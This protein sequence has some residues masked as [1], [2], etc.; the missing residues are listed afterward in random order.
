MLFSEV[1]G[2][3]HIKN[4]LITG[5]ENGRIPHAQLLVG[6]GVLPIAIA[7]AQYLLCSNKDGE[8]TGGNES[9]NLKF[10]KLS[11]PDLHFVYPVATNDKIKSHP[12]SAHFSEE[13][14]QFVLSN[15]YGSVFEWL[16]SLGIENK[17]GNISVD[18]AQDIVKA[19]SLKAYEGGH[20]VMIIWMAEKMNTSSANKLLKLIEEPP[21]KTVFLLIAEDEEQLL[22]TITSRCQIIRI[23]LLSEEV[24]A[25]G[26]IGRENAPY[27][28]AK[29]AARQASGSFNKALQL[30]KNKSEDNQFE[31]W[32][33]FWVRTA[34]RAKGNKTV[35]NELI[36]WSEEI[37]G[38]GREV[39][40][41]FL[42]YCTSFFRQALL[43]NY[44]ASPLV[45]LKIKD[46]K[47]ALEK[48]APFIHGGNVMEIVEAIEDA[49]YHIERNGNAKII[50][51]DLSIQLTRLLHKK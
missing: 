11:H 25:Q 3:D 32:V 18:E 33:I 12:V 43:I 13:W 5:V 27:D 46:P 7:Y 6:Q 15:P 21:D 39:Q 45:Y 50:F 8:N 14:R 44:N 10:N 40:K 42:D 47:F 41:K 34:F 2:L 16:Q 26:L 36:N 37:A 17:Q 19:L 30:Y 20:K 28:L 4:H 31:T 9:C 23:P 1:L 51:T 35:I 49:N 48:F 24:I 38:S 29:E 22:T